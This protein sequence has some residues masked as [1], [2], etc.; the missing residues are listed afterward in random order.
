MLTT[1]KRRI[2]TKLGM[3]RQ[4]V[5]VKVKVKAKVKVKVKAKAKV[6]V[7]KKMMMMIKMIL[8]AKR[9]RKRKKEF[10]TI[11][12]IRIK[13]KAM[14]SLGDKRLWRKMKIMSR[15]Q[16]K[17]N[18]KTK[19][20]KKLL[21]KRQNILNNL[22]KEKKKAKRKWEYTMISQ[23]L[24][25]MMGKMNTEMSQR[26]YLTTISKMMHKTEKSSCC[27]NTSLIRM[28]ISKLSLKTKK[29]GRNRY[30]IPF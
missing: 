7:K 23:G 1:M 6:K 25:R 24:I 2:H 8:L 5:K 14:I 22:K 30:C 10:L 12:M 13:I 18:S 4:K 17:N 19:L 20:T 15:S 28:K 29:T 27:L 16:I 11:R 3:S 9:K 26:E 21:S